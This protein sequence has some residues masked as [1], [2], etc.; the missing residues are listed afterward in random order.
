MK[1]VIIVGSKGLIGKALVKGLSK[2]FRIIEID[3]VNFK[4]KNYFKCNILDEKEV[5]SVLNKIFKKYKKIDCI[6][7]SAYPKKNNFSKKFLEPS[8]TDFNDNLSI[9]VGSLYCLIKYIYPHFKKNKKGNIINI[10][11]IYG[12]I[13]PKFEIYEKTSIKP[14]TVYGPIK[15]AQIMLLNYFSKIFAFRKQD[16]RCNT[17][18]PGGVFGGQ[19][20]QFVN[21][22]KK[23]CKSKGMISP[24]DLVGIAN[25]LV[26]DESKFIT[27][28]DIQADDGF[29]L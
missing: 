29:S 12:A 3:L 16:I 13:Q 24:S 27:G 20:K 4:T 15:S 18:S 14:P 23:Y 9:N 1:N 5:K 25:F 22:Y 21:N 2:N 28:Q 10:A 6:I 7:N 17:I 11:S 26:S 8:M 19:S